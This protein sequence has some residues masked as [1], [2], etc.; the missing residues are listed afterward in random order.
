MREITY[1]EERTLMSYYLDKIE[2]SNKLKFFWIFQ[3]P[4]NTI[5]IQL[6]TAIIFS[7]F[8]YTFGHGISSLVA[9]IILWECAIMINLKVKLAEDCV[10]DELFMEIDLKSNE[11]LKNEFPNDPLYVT[12]DDREDIVEKIIREKKRIT[13][14]DRIKNYHLLLIWVVAIYGIIFWLIGF[15]I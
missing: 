15:F 6:T 13:F 3:F 1:R 7:V 10:A 8:E 11:V 5:L 4:K 9:I 2:N 12:D 14:V